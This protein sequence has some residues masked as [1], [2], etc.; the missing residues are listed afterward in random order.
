MRQAARGVLAVFLGGLVAGCMVGDKP[1]EGDSD[2]DYLQDVVENKG[3]Q[4]RVWQAIV[5]CFVPGASVTPTVLNL[6]SEPQRYDTDGDGM[7]DGLERTWSGDPRS[8]D[9]DGDG[10]TDLREMELSEADAFEQR[11]G[12]KLNHADSDDDCLSDRDEVEGMEIPGLGM[13]QSDP[14]VADTDHDGLSD[15]EEFLRR[16][17]NPTNENT[18]GDDASD[19]FDMD[20]LH[21]VAIELWFDGVELLQESDAVP[22]KFFYGID[23][24]AGVKAPEPDVPAFN[25]SSGGS[26]SVPGAQSPGRVDVRDG[27]GQSFL[28]FQFWLVREDKGRTVALTNNLSQPIVT[29]NVNLREAQW[30]AG[31]STGAAKGER[32]ILLGVEARLD[33]RLELLAL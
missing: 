22:L 29:M 17:T 25:S 7:D 5:P 21:D 20:P 16:F 13:R 1:I 18:D 23:T 27:T 30:S 12:L 11:G 4:L 28:V 24:P 9:T 14:T 26:T 31:G 15:P 19:V 32:S 33:F 6:T 8:A 2:G 10:L 3:W